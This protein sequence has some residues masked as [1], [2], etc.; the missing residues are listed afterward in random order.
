M[1]WLIPGICSYLR[2]PH[3]KV[4]SYEPLRGFKSSVEPTIIMQIDNRQN[5]VF[6]P[7][8]RCMVKEKA[9]RMSC[10]AEFVKEIWISIDR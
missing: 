6:G 2:K 3:T 1:K 10:L 9:F 7:F 4:G 5:W 8:C